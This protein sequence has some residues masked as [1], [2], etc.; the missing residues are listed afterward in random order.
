MKR[1][2]INICWS[3][4]FLGMALCLCFWFSWSLHYDFYTENIFVQWTYPLSLS[5]ANETHHVNAT[6]IC[7]REDQK[8]SFSHYTGYV[9]WHIYHYINNDT[10]ALQFARTWRNLGVL[11]SFLGVQAILEFIRLKISVSGKM[12][13]HIELNSPKSV[14]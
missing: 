8:I 4:L 7:E 11:F 3:Y 12:V 2:W 5:H 14:R 1:S 13:K 9:C 6:Y 10:M